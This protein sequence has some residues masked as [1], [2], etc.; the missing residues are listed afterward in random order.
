LFSLPNPLSAPSHPLFTYLH[1]SLSSPTLSPLY[2]SLLLT[3]L[4]CQLFRLLLAKIITTIKLGADKIQR[5]TPK[6]AFNCTYQP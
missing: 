5:L 2:P 1:L 6:S 3:S 4:L